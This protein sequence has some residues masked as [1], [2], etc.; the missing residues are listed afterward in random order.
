MGIE[1]IRLKL[2]VLEHPKIRELQDIFEE[3]EPRLGAVAFCSWLRLIIHAARNC[4]DGH[5]QMTTRRLKSTA[6]WAGSGDQFAGALVEVGLLEKTKEGFLLH[7]WQD[8]QEYVANTSL[9]VAKAK[10]AAAARWSGE[11]EGVSEQ[12]NATSM[13]GACGKHAKNQSSN[14]P[15]I[16]NLLPKPKPKTKD[17]EL[18]ALSMLPPYLAEGEH[19][20]SMTHG[21]SPETPERKDLIAWFNKNCCPPFKANKTMGKIAIGAVGKLLDFLREVHGVNM[22]ERREFERFMHKAV[23]AYQSTDS[24][25]CSWGLLNVCKEENMVKILDGVYEP[26]DDASDWGQQMRAKAKAGVK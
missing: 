7:D 18:D 9:R 16:T 3:I 10:K 15:T 26:R 22:D 17:Q 23:K 4:Q 8:H 20:S 6:R 5:L 2:D 21:V 19:A 24:I 12:E 1:D 14:A 13:P 11:K 25:P